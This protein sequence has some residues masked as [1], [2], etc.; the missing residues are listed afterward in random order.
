LCWATV[1]RL[2]LCVLSLS[3]PGCTPSI[4]PL[5]F[6]PELNKAITALASALSQV[7]E[8]LARASR[9][10]RG[11]QGQGSTPVYGEQPARYPGP[12]GL[13]GCPQE[14]HTCMHTLSHTHVPDAHKQ[15]PMCAQSNSH[16]PWCLTVLDQ[17]CTLARTRMLSL[18]FLITRLSVPPGL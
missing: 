11:H 6:Q 8:P 13:H 5:G 3:S 17:L 16:T 18:H 12:M 10:V 1:I 2:D 15:S 9:E 4:S 14:H 7:C